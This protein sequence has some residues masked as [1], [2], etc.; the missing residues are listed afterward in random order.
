MK[1]LNR[2]LIKMCSKPMQRIYTRI[3]A[4]PFPLKFNAFSFYYTTDYAASF[5]YLTAK[6]YYRLNTLVILWYI[7][8]LKF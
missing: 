8:N 3:P 4:G 5:P 1:T 6:E 2:I 7:C